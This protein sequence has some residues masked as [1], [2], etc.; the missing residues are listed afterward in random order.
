MFGKGRSP[1]WHKTRTF[2]ASN[3]DYAVPLAHTQA[4]TMNCGHSALED[5]AQ[6][7][8][9]KSQEAIKEEEDKQALAVMIAEHKTKE[10][11]FKKQEAERQMLAERT[12]V[13]LSMA[14]AP[15]TLLRAPRQSAP[16]Q[17]A[18]L[19]KE[20]EAMRQQACNDPESMADDAVGNA[21]NTFQSTPIQ[22]E[23]PLTNKRVYYTQI[24]EGSKAPK[25]TANSA[26]SSYAR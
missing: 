23:E 2:N 11:E 19:P 20:E 10:A 7:K 18:V 14:N 6:E 1:N 22:K 21:N 26:F 16:V 3:M 8:A 9:C 5:Y 25:S 13:A 4:D 15:T 17:R 12:P 24:I